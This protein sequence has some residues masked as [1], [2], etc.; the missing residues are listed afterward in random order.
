MAARWAGRK[1]RPW[2]RLCARVYAEETH[3]IRCG[4][5]VDKDLPYR[6]PRTGQVNRWSKSVDHKRA[7]HLGGAPLAR[8]N[9]GL[10][11][12]GCNSSHGARVGK[13][14]ASTSTSPSARFRS[15]LPW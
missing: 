8:D 9:V 1:G 11:H 7:L 12:F 5:W 2:R 3:C 13:P 6:N 4:R 10:A 14:N 15:A